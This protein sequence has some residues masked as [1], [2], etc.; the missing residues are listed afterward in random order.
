MIA[1]AP[2]STIAL[3]QTFSPASR[4]FA[5]ST[6][7]DRQNAQIQIVCKKMKTDIIY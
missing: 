2:T 7:A 6:I 5:D 1:D 3:G 4:S